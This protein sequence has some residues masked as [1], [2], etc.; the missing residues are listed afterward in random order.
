MT[1]DEEAVYRP[2]RD[3]YIAMR[4]ADGYKTPKKVTALDDRQKQYED[5]RTYQLSDH[6]PLWAEFHVDF[7]DEYLDGL[8]KQER[9]S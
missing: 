5:W 3:A 1:T 9:P 2:Y 8:A 4:H 7:S 6:L